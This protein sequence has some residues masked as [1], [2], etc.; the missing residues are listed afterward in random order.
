[1]T[2]LQVEHGVRDY[3][4]WKNAFDSDPVGREAGG[5]RSYRIMR[6]AGDRGRVV[7]ELEFD[8]MARA[9]AFREK[10]RQLWDSAGADLGLDNPSARILEVVESTTLG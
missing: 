5:V 10:L 1:M 6:L 3:E 4:R 7:I 2:I 8:A 9:E